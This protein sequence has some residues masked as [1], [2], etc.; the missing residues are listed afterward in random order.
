MEVY[1]YVLVNGKR[2]NTGLEIFNTEKRYLLKDADI[3]YKTLRG[4]TRNAKNVEVQI[5]R[6]A[7]KKFASC[8]YFL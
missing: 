4:R 3:F 1:E 6:I 7:R 5:N 8:K 2:E